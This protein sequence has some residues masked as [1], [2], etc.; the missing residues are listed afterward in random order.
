MGYREWMR[1]T[2]LGPSMVGRILDHVIY[3]VREI[4]ERGAESEEVICEGWVSRPS[5]PE[6]TQRQEHLSHGKPLS[7][8]RAAD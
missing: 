4:I 5:H 1:L 2:Y 6:A 8:W 7:T 3:R